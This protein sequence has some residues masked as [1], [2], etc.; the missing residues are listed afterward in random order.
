M[1]KPFM[2]Y[3][4]NMAKLATIANKQTMFLAHILSK[5]EFDS[6]LKM[7]VIDLTPRVKRAIL[8]DIGAVSKDPLNLARTYTKQLVKAGLI[9]Q[10]ERG[11]YAIDPESYSYS[12]YVSKELRLRAR[13]I[14][15]K[16]QYSADGAEKKEVWVELKSG[17]MREI[18]ITDKDI[19]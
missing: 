1:K 9:K 8:Q 12:T 7:L 11:C 4:E 13:N 16:V 14:F 2:T 15:E 17:E 10:I 5:A 3:Y 19:Y 18:T 6:D